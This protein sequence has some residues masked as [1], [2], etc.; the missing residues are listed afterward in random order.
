LTRGG[1]LIR[2]GGKDDR[3]RGGRGRMVDQ[4]VTWLARV[5]DKEGWQSKKKLDSLV[6]SRVKGCAREVRPY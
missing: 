5:V 1:G 3:G 4:D 6:W 2:H